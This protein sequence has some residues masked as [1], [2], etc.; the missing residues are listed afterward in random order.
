MSLSEAAYVAK[1]LGEAL[2]RE[3]YESASLAIDSLVEDSGITETLVGD[4]GEVTRMVLAADQLA[5]QR[6]A[7]LEGKV[8][9]LESNIRML[10]DH[11]GNDTAI[12]TDTITQN[13]PMSS[14]FVQRR[15][16]GKWA[17]QANGSISPIAEALR[18]FVSTGAVSTSIDSRF[19]AGTIAFGGMSLAMD[20]YTGDNLPPGFSPRYDVRTVLLTAS[21]FELMEQTAKPNEVGIRW[22]LGTSFNFWENS[23]SAVAGST[24]LTYVLANGTTAAVPVQELTVTDTPT[25]VNGYALMCVRQGS[26]ATTYGL[27]GV[28]PVAMKFGVE[29]MSTVAFNLERTGV[30]SSVTTGPYTYVT[31][32]TIE[33]PTC[34]SQFPGF[35]EVGFISVAPGSIFKPA[36][37]D[38]RVSPLNGCK[39]ISTVMTTTF[40]VSD[41]ASRYVSSNLGSAGAHP[42]LGSVTGSEVGQ[43]LGMTSAFSALISAVT[44][45]PIIPLVPTPLTEI[46]R[47]TA[48]PDASSTKQEQST[49]ELASGTWE[50]L[51][52]YAESALTWVL[53]NAGTVASVVG[54]LL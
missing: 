19:N 14:I 54:A 44:S 1:A 29:R 10:L 50:T 33:G 30:E 18:I 6:I 15:L 12:D 51:A 11:P 17:T 25:L 35:S 26:S 23:V 21:Q 7:S 41:V 49:S 22:T 42:S 20:G 32:I 48:D 16:A 39:R 40:M 37:H 9:W 36:L 5:S 38:W 34:K 13:S 3:D 47:L 31:S 8:S 24:S 52:G 4:V 45:Q 27:C 28:L 43:N 46:L 53:E 2:E